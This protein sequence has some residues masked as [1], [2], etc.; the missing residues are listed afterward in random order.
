MIC[1]W[2]PCFCLT[3]PLL[4]VLL[5][6][7]LL[8]SCTNKHLG[9]TIDLTLVEMVSTRNKFYIQVGFETDRIDIYQI[10]FTVNTIFK[11]VYLLTDLFPFPNYDN[12]KVNYAPLH[13][14][15]NFY[16]VE[17]RID[18]VNIIWRLSTLIGG[19][20]LQMPLRALFQ[21]RTSTCV[22][23]ETFL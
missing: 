23:P 12:L 14:K 17:S 8:F 3:S 16:L 21:A 10:L 4:L 19:G 11:F 9:I 15:N 13:I 22:E 5:L 20:R 7:L 1:L 18:T 2:D 6:L